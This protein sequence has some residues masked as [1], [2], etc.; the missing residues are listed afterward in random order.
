M[1]RV[2]VIQHVEPERPAMLGEVLRQGG[3]R[4]DVVH[5]YD[6]EAVPVD[7]GA[8]DALVVLGGPMSAGSDEDFG[9]RG[10]ELALIADAVRHRRPMLGVC[11]GAQLLALVA[12]S[13]IRPGREAEIGWGSVRLTAAAARDRLFGGL[14]GEIPVLHWHGETFDLPV[15][16]VHLA[17][18]ASYEAQAFRLGDVAWGL[19]FHVEADRGAVERMVSSFPEDAAAA[20]G[21]GA[22]ILAATDDALERM[23]AVREAVLGGFVELV[24]ACPS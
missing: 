24:G 5:V 12:G 18:S 13:S 16:A 22:A 7:L 14:D 21:G 1:P 15:G 10:G 19:Q 8:H 17:A 23:A 2:L 6:G 20:P 3:C 9:S 4:I 11:L